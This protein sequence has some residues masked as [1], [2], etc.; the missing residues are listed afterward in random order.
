MKVG[1]VMKTKL[2]FYFDTFVVFPNL[3]FYSSWI[4]DF[5]SWCEPA[6][7]RKKFPYLDGYPKFVKNF[8][9]F[10]EKPQLV[11]KRSDLKFKDKSFAIPV[12]NGIPSYLW[13]RLNHRV[14]VEKE[15][16]YNIHELKLEDFIRDINKMRLSDIDPTQSP[17]IHHLLFLNIPYTINPI[18]EQID[19]KILGKKWYVIDY[20]NYIP[21]MCEEIDLYKDVIDYI[22]DNDIN[23]MF[24]T[25][26]EANIDREKF[27]NTIVKFCISRNFSPDRIFYLN[28]TF[29]DNTMSYRIKPY[30]NKSK[31]DSINH[32]SVLGC[33]FLMNYH[34]KCKHYERYK[35][36]VN[37]EKKKRSKHFYY[38]IGST[39][40]ERI[41]ALKYF[42]SKG[43]LDKMNWAS[44]YKIN[45]KEFNK[46]TPKLF[47]EDLKNNIATT[48]PGR[49][50][51]FKDSLY[52]P[53]KIVE[54]SYMSIVF[55]TDPGGYDDKLYDDERTN[56]IIDEKI[57]KPIVS[58]HP[59]I[60]FGNPYT[61]DYFRDMEYETFPEIF[62]ESY[63]EIYNY[64][65]RLEF[66]IK[67]VEKISKLPLDEVHDLY[68]KVYP[69]LVKNRDLLLSMDIKKEYESW[70]EVE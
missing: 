44:K 40:Y 23:L 54:D 15:K 12:P 41:E 21:T 19:D 32:Y 30:M 70:Y 28:Q 63:D 62:D 35:P 10:E 65:E 11:I 9:E 17:L 43:L 47:E 66:V 34:E 59:F 45:A 1:L 50:Y 48:I 7:H 51:E 5:Y 29:L 67:Q 58:L 46:I 14:D 53:K 42:Y 3:E 36:S 38:V 24:L 39:K 25:P 13:D 31:I 20:Y 16:K 68:N 33:A 22:R 61:L 26:Q 37:L 60:Y 69:K 2:N 55:S 52:I 18:G 56:K 27:Y 4:E 49:G 57:L 6:S 64:D 8:E